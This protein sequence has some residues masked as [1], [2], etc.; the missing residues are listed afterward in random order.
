MISEVK[1]THDFRHIQKLTFKARENI[2]EDP[3]LYKEL[4]SPKGD[5]QNTS[6]EVQRTFIKFQTSFIEK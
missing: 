2:S 4:F 5:I 1:T 3:V 6:V